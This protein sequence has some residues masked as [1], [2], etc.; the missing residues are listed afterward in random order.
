MLMIG[1][2]ILLFLVLLGL[3]ALRGRYPRSPEVVDSSRRQIRAQELA[4][5]Q[6]LLQEAHDV[7]IEY[8]DVVS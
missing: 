1:V 7:V 5:L 6:A 3:V 4:T 2:G 8:S